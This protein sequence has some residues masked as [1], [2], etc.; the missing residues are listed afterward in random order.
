[1]DYKAYTL[2]AILLASLALVVPIGTTYA[3]TED[4]ATTNATDAATTDEAEVPAIN[5]TGGGEWT[6][7]DLTV[8]GQTYP[9]EYMITGGTVENM[10]IHSENQ[11]L[12]VTL[13]SVSN[14]TLSLR[15][16][17]EVID[18]QTVEGSDADFAAFIDNAEYTQPG[19]I[20]P[21]EDMR[22]L[23]IGFPAGAGSIDVIGTSVIP[24]FSTIAVV[25]LAVAIVGIIIATARHSRFNFG[26]RM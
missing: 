15:L 20:E 8:E 9:I 22:T 21:A 16:P 12:G 10:T 5:A 1:M 18:S 14:G 4:A 2:M 19:E 11:T 17:R 3:Q 6:P 7:F 13:N 25:V 26:P 23:L 24:E